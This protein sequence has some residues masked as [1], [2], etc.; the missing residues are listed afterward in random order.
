MARG[1]YDQS[2]T[3]VARNALYRNRKF[4][5]QGRVLSP[6]VEA[7]Q[8]EGETRAL[9]KQSS[10]DAFEQERLDE[11][12]RQFDESQAENARQFNVSERRATSQF[13]QNQQVA[14][15]QR[16]DNDVNLFES[17]VSGLCFIT[18]AVC[19]HKGKDDDC[20]ELEVLR[21]YRDKW[22]VAN[23]PKDV[24]TYYQIAPDIVEGINQ[25]V[26]AGE[27]WES[28]YSDSIVPCVNYIKEG[29]N[30]QAYE[31]YRRMVA[32]LEEICDEC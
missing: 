32:G 16:K 8:I 15:K 26:D 17:I 1:V 24:K 22:M 2:V 28:V 21:Q 31:E 11:N 30:E 13:L 5:T 6:T 20:E 3:N 27:I 23:Y 12:A 9:A 7:A 29:K 25:R 19:E 10:Q 18:T 14:R 4:A